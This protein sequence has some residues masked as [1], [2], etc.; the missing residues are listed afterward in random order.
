LKFTNFYYN[1]W[2]KENTPKP[3][4]PSLLKALNLVKP[5]TG[6]TVFAKALR[7][8]S[9]AEKSRNSGSPSKKSKTSGSSISDSIEGSIT[10]KRAQSLRQLGPYQT[11][12]KE[13]WD[14]LPEAEREQ[15]EQAAKQAN[16]PLDEGDD[17]DIR[18]NE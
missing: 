14:G 1:K 12:L 16:A 3:A 5:D 8:A 13:V 4:Q 9:S 15:W 10:E 7:T 17:G 2:H 11:T 6:R 18:I